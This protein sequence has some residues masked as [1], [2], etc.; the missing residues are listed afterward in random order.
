MEQTPEYRSVP[1][2]GQQEMLEGA[3][4]RWMAYLLVKNSDMKKYGSLMNGLASQYSMKN[5]QYPK[6]I[7]EA[8]NIM[9]NH[10]HDQ[11]NRDHQ[12]GKAKNTTNRNHNKE[13]AET[14]TSFVQGKKLICYCCGK[15]G[16]RVPDC[17]DRNCIAHDDWFINKAQQ[18]YQEKIIENKS[19]DNNNDQ[20]KTNQDNWSGFQYISTTA[21]P[22]FYSKTESNNKNEVSTSYEDLKDYIILDNGSTLSLFSNPELV[23]NIKKSDRQMLMATNAGTSINDTVAHVPGFGQ[24]WFDPK[25]IA[26]IFGFKDM[27][28]K[29]RIKYDSEQEDAFLVYTQDGIIKFESTPEGLY[30]YKVS[31]NYLKNLHKKKNNENNETSKTDYTTSNMV[32]TLEENMTG[33]TDRQVQQAKLARKIYHNIG[34]PTI[35]NFKLLI[36]T[37]S[38]KNC[39]ITIDDINNAEKIFGPSLSS[40]KGKSTRTKPEIVKNDHIKIPRELVNMNKNIELCID[41]MYINKIP[42]LTAID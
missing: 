19:T 5:D 2:T 31:K 1:V 20:N 18:H 23:S 32:A 11:S 3:F 21:R 33:F 37:N 27:K 35:K 39:P 15:K 12:Q 22:S 25:A 40:L 30:R 28:K 9:V 26:N 6:D 4:D 34:T 36:K 13:G 24:V 41:T 42:M 38:I 29:Y 7:V 10:K 8:T 16:H 14:E 17:K